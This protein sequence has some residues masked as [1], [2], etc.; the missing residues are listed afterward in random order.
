LK[1]G[2][3]MSDIIDMVKADIIRCEQAQSNKEG[4]QK[5]YS[6]LIAR[7]STFYPN[8]KDEIPTGSKIAVTGGFD[9]R[10]ELSSIKSKLETL[11]AAGYSFKIPAKSSDKPLVH[12]DNRNE[13]HISVNVTFDMV[14]QQVE[15]MSALSQSQ[16]DEVLSKIKE[17]EEIV[18][19][20]DKK[21]AKWEKAKKV[22]LWIA[23]K[24]VDVGIAMLPLILKIG[25]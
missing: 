20:K 16:I 25:Q 13:N 8:F 7:Y 3:N 17:L 12:I 14:R 4:S 18:N 23:D 15:E 5:L 19:S 10:W 6:N 24:G 1:E 9:Y 21:S 22:L 11:L 2:V